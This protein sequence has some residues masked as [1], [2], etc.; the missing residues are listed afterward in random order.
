[1]AGEISQPRKLSGEGAMGATLANQK[2]SPQT[3]NNAGFVPQEEWFKWVD[4]LTI[5]EKISLVNI[6][7]ISHNFKLQVASD[8]PVHGQVIQSNE[9][10]T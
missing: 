6:G 4:D 9:L 10:K 3:N 7:M 2:F 1:M 8:I 5:L